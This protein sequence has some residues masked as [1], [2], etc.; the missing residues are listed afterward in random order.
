M[1]GEDGFG[2][3]LHRGDGAAPEVFTA[4]ANVKNFKGPGMKR[5]IYDSTTHDTP[6]GWRT[7]RGGLKDGGDVELDINFDPANHS[8]LIEDFDDPDPR[9]YR[10]IWPD[11]TQCALTAVLSELSPASPHDDLLTA[12]IK[13]AV[14]GKPVWT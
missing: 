13:F 3:A 10:L 5:D 9:N 14:S 4:I 12:S 6:E 7:K 11:G 1:S 2:T 8:L